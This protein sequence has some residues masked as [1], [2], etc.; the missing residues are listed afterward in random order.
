MNI[1]ISGIS[2]TGL[3]PLALMASDAGLFVCGTDL[4]EGAVTGELAAKKVEMEIGQTAQDGKFLQK[5]VSDNCKQFP[6]PVN[7]DPFGQWIT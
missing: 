4:A 7:Q 1:Y 5:I 3:G 6:K 2:G